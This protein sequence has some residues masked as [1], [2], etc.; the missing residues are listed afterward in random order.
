VKIF[1]NDNPNSCSWWAVDARRAERFDGEGSVQSSVWFP[2]NLLSEFDV[3]TQTEAKLIMKKRREFEIA[4][5]RRV[6]RKSDFLRYAAYELDL[7]RLRRKRVEKISKCGSQR[8][9]MGGKADWVCSL[10]WLAEERSPRSVS[11]YAIVKRVFQIFERAVRKFRGD[12]GLWMEYIRVAEKV[13]AKSLVGKIT[14]R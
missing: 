5:V 13:G 4:M 3:K 12:V 6:A 10:C 8:S 7:E 1:F 2:K 9:G 14:A 11:D